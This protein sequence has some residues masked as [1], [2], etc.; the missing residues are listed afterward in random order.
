MP[1]YRYKSLSDGCDYCRGGFELMQSISA[2]PLSKCPKCKGKVKK[3]PA[4][5]SGFTPTLSDSNLRDK[6]FTKL[7]KRGDGTYEKTT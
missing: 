1:I 4:S 7:K 6:G 5:C 3:I 2:Q